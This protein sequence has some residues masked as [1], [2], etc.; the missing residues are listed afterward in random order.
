MNTLVT[1]LN[2]VNV[3]W[4]NSLLDSEFAYFILEVTSDYLMI[5]CEHEYFKLVIIVDESSI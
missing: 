5:V 2:N 4:V 1:I 3:E